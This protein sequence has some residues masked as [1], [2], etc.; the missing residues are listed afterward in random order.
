MAKQEYDREDLIAEA[1]ALVHRVEMS[2][3]DFPEPVVLGLRSNLW[4][5]IYFHPDRVF[6]FNE[7]GAL[8][9]AF[10]DGLLYRS[11]PQGLSRLRRERGDPNTSAL[12][13]EELSPDAM[14]D[15]LRDLEEW[16]R[17]LGDHLHHGRAEVLRE[18][19]APGDSPP[20]WERLVAQA[21]PARLAGR[22][23]AR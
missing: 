22:V 1:K 14:R 23:G 11:G 17:R 6:H 9:R 19:V 7:V 3:P 18:V 10:V 4:F 15:F 20:N 21:L 2:V 13:R 8:R 16:L 12:L 5:S